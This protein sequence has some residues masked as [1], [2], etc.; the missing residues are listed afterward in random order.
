MKVGVRLH[1]RLFGQNDVLDNELNYKVTKI[2]KEQKRTFSQLDAEMKCLKK[3]LLKTSISS[4]EVRVNDVDKSDRMD[5]WDKP[6]TTVLKARMMLQSTKAFKEKKT[7]EKRNEIQVKEM[8]KHLI[9]LEDLPRIRY[10]E[11][12]RE[13]TAHFKTS[14]TDG[15]ENTKCNSARNETLSDIFPKRILE[16]RNSVPAFSTTSF[17]EVNHFRSPGS[18][19]FEFGDAN[20]E[21]TFDM[22][23]GVKPRTGIRRSCIP[24]DTQLLPSNVQ[25][26][27][28]CQ[29]ERRR[30]L[31]NIS[32]DVNNG[33]KNGEVSMLYSNSKKH[34]DSKFLDYLD[35]KVNRTVTPSN[36]ERRIQMK[37]SAA[38]QIYKYLASAIPNMSNQ[39]IADIQRQRNKQ[40]KRSCNLR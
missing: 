27:I 24:T 32:V 10:E 17:D 18:D 36:A 35:I 22:N 7:D 4:G 39:T 9:R 13:G 26:K 16:R 28:P 37:K 3:Q 15:T 40:D 38:F 12:Q 1:K 29:N 5:D 6:S 34:T 2:T 25:L 14:K 8:P 33:R 30:S 20:T 23:Q 19:Q 21:K 11:K 31:P